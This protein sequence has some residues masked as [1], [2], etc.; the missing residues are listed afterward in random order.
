MPAVDRGDNLEIETPVVETPEVETPELEVKEPEV[1]EPESKEP[2]VK[3]RDDQ[4][5]FIPKGRF[6]EAVN[7]ASESQL[8]VSRKCISRRHT[9]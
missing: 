7:A 1:K 6:D 3:E 5:R 9:N 2:E 8:Q 4:G